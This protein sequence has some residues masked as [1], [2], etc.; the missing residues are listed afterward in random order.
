M[1]VLVRRA[2]IAVAGAVMFSGMVGVAPAEAADDVTIN[3]VAV[4]DFHGR[5]DEN[6]V[7]WAATVEDLLADGPPD[8]SFLLSA[9]DNVGASV[10]ASAV[11]NDDPTID[12]LNLLGV[13]A[14][15]VGNHEFDRGYADLV[16]HI[17]PRANFPILG[18]NVRKDGG[19]PALDA[20]TTFTVDGVRMA[21]VGA[22][23]E[24]TPELVDPAGIAGL[25]FGDPVAA[26]NTEVAR[27]KALPTAEQPDVIVAVIHEGAEWGT[28]NLEQAMQSSAAFRSI[29]E[30][31]SPDV[32]AIISGHTHNTY[33][34]N[35]PVPG[36]PDRTR[37]IIE[38]GH[39]GQN[40]GQV[41]LTVDPETKQVTTSSARNVARVTTSD[42]DLVADD[43]TLAQVARIRDDAVA[44]E[45]E[46]AEIVEATQQQYDAAVADRE[47]AYA[48][49]DEAKADYDAAV[50]K[51]E[52]AISAASGVKQEYEAAAAAGQTY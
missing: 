10:P 38:T 45:K 4:N 16:Q 5:I 6:V 23:T 43:S 22:V 25:S 2:P 47:E 31:T 49:A 34:Y 1:K 21:V 32:D 35:T 19:A 33:V 28:W 29:V 39:Y 8:R 14:S 50:A 18:A 7:Q 15:A 11:Q 51:R 48:A 52:S 12:L 26:I 42:A 30:D 40:V 3:L 41:T 20:S 9:G 44:Y 46:H 13:D 27:L 24:S 37:P 36:E 17:I